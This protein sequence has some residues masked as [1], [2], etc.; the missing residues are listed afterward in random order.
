[1]H[2]KQPSATKIDYLSIKGWE[3]ING[4]KKQVGVS[5]LMSNKTNFQPKVIKTEGEGHFIFIK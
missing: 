3:K 1:M 2:K 4:L 5:I